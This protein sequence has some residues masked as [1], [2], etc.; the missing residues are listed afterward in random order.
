[1]T[2]LDRIVTTKKAELKLRKA[3]FPESYWE[4]SPLLE[5]KPDSLVQHLK[6]S[7]SGIIAEFKRRSPSKAVINQSVSVREVVTG[8][9]TAGACG[10]SIL[11]DNEYFGGSLDDLVQARACSNLPLLR[12]EFIIDPYQITEAKAF[13]ADVVLLIAAL[14][15]ETQ[16]KALSAHA[17]GLQ[18]E[19]LVEIHD[20]SELEKCLQ[21]TVDII[22]VNNRNLKTFD[23]SLDT[24]KDLAAKIP[25]EFLK[26]SESGLQD[27]SAIIALKNYG[28]EG[29]LIGENFMKTTHP[30]AAAQEFIQQLNP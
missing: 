7:P 11:T 24:S 25:A 9:A 22:G 8:Y 23:V 2:I 19:V 21:P 18:L 27:P 28:F 5:R 13:G 16:I 29:F 30:S 26:I 17:K 10:A 15:D 14:L 4:Q 20:A 1:M 6:N 3:Q 12:K